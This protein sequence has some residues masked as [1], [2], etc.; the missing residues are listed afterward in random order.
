MPLTT[1]AKVKEQLDIP[2]EETGD[3]SLL[4][5]LIT[6]ADTFVEN[7]C[8]RYFEAQDLTEY[9]RGKGGETVLKLNEYPVNSVTSIHDDPDRSYGSTALID[10]SYYVVDTKSGIVRLDGVKF[11]AGFDN[12]KVVYN[13]GYSTIPFDLEQAVL[14]L[15]ALKYNSR[16]KDRLGVKSRSID[17]Q[18]S[19]VFITDELLPEIKVV[20]DMYR[21]VR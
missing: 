6:V 16:D 4:T 9:H 13:A 20:L 14:D 11:Q 17:G 10:A 8:R 12:I 2:T 19:I 21:K 18:S 15:I 7:Y 5:R 1:L 3:D